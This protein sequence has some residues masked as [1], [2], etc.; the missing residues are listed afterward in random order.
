MKYAGEAERHAGTV[1]FPFSERGVDGHS[2][3][4]AESVNNATTTPVLDASPSTIRGS[5]QWGQR[6]GHESDSSEKAT[7]NRVSYYSFLRKVVFP[8][9]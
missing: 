9:F 1:W 3:I 6:T 4:S 2:C 7:L 5:L 8:T